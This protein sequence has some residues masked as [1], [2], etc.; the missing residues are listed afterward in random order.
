MKLGGIYISVRAKTDQLK[1]DLAKAKTATERAAVHMKHAIS[2]INFAKVGVAAAAFTAAVVLMGKKVVSLGREFE[3]TMKTVQAWSGAAGDELKDLTAIARK[4]GATTEHTATEAAGALKFLA[5]AGF[6][7]KKSIAALPGTLNLATAGQVDLASATDITTDVLTAFGLQVD[8][9][10]RVNDTFITASS[11]SNTNVMM[12]GQS[13]KMVAPTAKLFGLTIEQTA[14][15]LGTLANA[16]VKSEMAGSGLNMVLLRSAKAAKKLGLEAGTPLITILRK[17][18]EEQWGAV[19]IGEAFGAR[20]VKTAAILMNGID[21]YEKLTKKIIENKGA[22]SELAAIVRDSLDVDLKTLNSTIQEE[23]LRT[24]ENHKD[25]MRRIVQE[26]TEWVKQN[27]QLIDQM[28]ELTAKSLGLAAAL[29]KVSLGGLSILRQT[30]VNLDKVL[31]ISSA[32]K[33]YKDLLKV[34]QFVID[35]FSGKIDLATGL[36]KGAAERITEEFDNIDASVVTLTSDTDQLGEAS[37]RLGAAIKNTGTVIKEITDADAEAM[38]AVYQKQF[39]VQK[40]YYTDSIIEK[41]K[42]NQMMLEFDMELKDLEF[43]NQIEHAQ[44]MADI[45]KKMAEDA[46]EAARKKLE[47]LESYFTNVAGVLGQMS[48][49]LLTMSST[50]AVQ[51]RKDFNRQKN[52][53]MGQAIM[54]TAAGVTKEYAKG[55][56]AGIV[57]AMLVAALGA[58][59]VATIS[60]QE[61]KYA[62]GGVFTNDIFNSATPFNNSV[63]GEAGPE[64]I[65][66]L[67]KSPSGELGV[68]ATGGGGT[69]VTY[70]IQAIDSK[71]FLDTVRRNP[72]AITMVMNQEMQRGNSALNNNIRRVSQ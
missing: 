44:K 62:K 64:A 28:G 16:G 37:E 17:M 68:K 50:G 2:K 25:E 58:V 43:Q 35:A 20:Q 56:Y 22:T 51:D 8:D 7:A 69:Q 23:L 4:M 40:Q 18:K 14:G 67:A 57:M 21:S 59:Q 70:M 65:I 15:F 45:D 10:S 19:K 24:F 29:A 12:L 31:G 34:Q 46:A 49:A 53:N 63:M 60:K 61:Y 9:L 42:Y 47:A 27:P 66:P 41:E 55:G 54:N 30:W 3:S 11:N 13:F 38:A 6:S 5:A 72:A 39:N 48:S 71:S 33:S 26:T 32:V 36:P 52:L 1:R